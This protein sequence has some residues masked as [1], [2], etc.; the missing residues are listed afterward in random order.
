MDIL[1][2]VL[3]MKIEHRH[4]NGVEKLPLYLSSGYDFRKA[5][6]DLCECLLVTP[7]DELPTLPALKKQIVKIQQIENLPVAICVDSMS[8][9]RRENMIESRVPFI[10]K[11]E[12]VYLPFMGTFLQAKNDKQIASIERFMISTQ[13]LF[14]MYIY[15]K[16]KEL[17]LTE[18]TR[19]LPYSAMTINRAAK[20]LDASKLFQTRKDGVNKII[21]SELSKKALY[22]GAK[23]YLVSPVIKTY[24]LPKDLVTNKIKMVLAGISALSEHSMLSEGTLMHYA[25]AQGNVNKEEIKTELLNIQKQVLI[26]EWRY[27]PQLFAKEKIADPIS[28]ALSLLNNQD[29]RVEMAIEEMLNAL[30]EKIDG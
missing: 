6:I 24:Y 29:E 18:A 17:Y 1:T 9:F 23:R 13:L 10:V 8:V 27:N 3:G 20:Q 4:W 5:E 15:Q 22:E 2:D 25:I 7:K 21:F 12:Q 19:C 30:W 28:I 16:N 26:E 14:L 11:D